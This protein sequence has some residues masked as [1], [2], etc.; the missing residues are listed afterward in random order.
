M[1]HGTADR[2]FAAAGASYERSRPSYPAAAV[3]LLVDELGIDSGT[4][5]V[6]VGAGTGKLTRMLA[7][8]GA[9]LIAVEPVAAMLRRLVAA[10]PSAH[11][12]GGAAEAL[13][14]AGGSADVV[15]AATAFH[16]FRAEQAL[17]EIGRVLRPG[18]G[19][20]LVWNN[21]ERDVEWVGAVWG[22]IDEYRG[23][24]PRSSDL[25]WQAPFDRSTAFTP[26]QH[27]RL[28][29]Y[30]DVTQDELLERVTAISFIAALSDRD[31]ERV[32]QRVRD[33]VASHPYLAG[34]EQ[35]RLPY[36]TDAYWCH[37]S[38]RAHPLGSA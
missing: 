18:G 30:Q 1:I 16:W 5:V 12:V 8:T 35:F 11:P 2:G 20:G 26:L 9:T 15:I 25:R 33:V 36:R 34:R 29:H 4:A 37:R 28:A 23:D 7:P 21:P 14:L 17:R 13:P 31:R 3:E 19:L 32:L 24:A 6:D 38:G 27:R 10:V 22:I